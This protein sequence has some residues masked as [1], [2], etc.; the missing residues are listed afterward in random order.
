M[1]LWPPS[2][3]HVLLIEDNPSQAM[4]IITAMQDAG[5]DVRVHHTSS[6]EQAITYLKKPGAAPGLVLLDL[7]MPEM[8]GHQL[9]AVIKNHPRWKAIPVIVLSSSDDDHDRELAYDQHANGYLVKPT[10]YEG[11]K[12]LASGLAA[13]WVHLNRPPYSSLKESA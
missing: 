6:G 11:L 12:R 13:Y 4:L 2:P 8:D 9:L 5:T 7:K 1:N 10:S 3:M